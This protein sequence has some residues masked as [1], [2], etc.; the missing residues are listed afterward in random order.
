MDNVC[1]LSYTPIPIQKQNLL[2]KRRLGMGV[3]GYASALAMMKTAFNSEEA[4]FMTEELMQFITNNA[5]QTSAL[6]AAEKGTFP[7]YNEKEFL[8]SRFVQENL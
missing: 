3:L 8:A 1:D 5:Y 6:L 4:L 7:L 2:E